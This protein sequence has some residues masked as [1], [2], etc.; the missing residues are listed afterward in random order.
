MDVSSSCVCCDAGYNSHF[1]GIFNADYGFLRAHCEFGERNSINIS[2]RM[3]ASNGRQLPDAAQQKEYDEECLE[4]WH[5]QLDF[6]SGATLTPD[7]NL[8]IKGPGRRRSQSRETRKAAVVSVYNTVSVWCRAIHVT[9]SR[10]LV[11]HSDY[12]DVN[13]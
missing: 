6:A 11:C 12:Q 5:R 2:M 7:V 4:V 3:S 9:L 1:E 13:V 10:Q 8:R